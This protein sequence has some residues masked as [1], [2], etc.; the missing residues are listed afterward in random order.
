MINFTS[1]KRELKMRKNANKQIID[2]IIRVLKRT[3]EYENA[4]KKRKIRLIE[5]IKENIVIKRWVSFIFV[6]IF[7]II[8]CVNIAK[9][10]HASIFVFEKNIALNAL[11]VRVEDDQN[12]AWKNISNEEAKKDKINKFSIY[13]WNIDNLLNFD[14]LTMQVFIDQDNNEYVEKIKSIEFARKAIDI[15]I[16]VEHDRRMR[17]FKLRRDMWR[18]SIFSLLMKIRHFN[19]CFNLF[20]CFHQLFELNVSVIDREMSDSHN[21][22]NL[23]SNQLLKRH[24]LWY[25]VIITRLFHLAKADYFSKHDCTLSFY[26][27]R[28]RRFRRII[29]SRELMK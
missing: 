24:D 23:C 1:L 29:R 7:V 27:S 9:K 18:K 11:N 14:L 17:D 10:Q 22:N 2:R 28:W 15:S 4:S 3:N 21:C 16:N 19:R 8:E 5:K 20:N 13:F 26:E 12:S 6:V 25:L